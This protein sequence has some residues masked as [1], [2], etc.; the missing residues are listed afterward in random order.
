MTSDSDVMGVAEKRVG[1]LNFRG[2][3]KFMVERYIEH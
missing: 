1:S 3:M 2:M